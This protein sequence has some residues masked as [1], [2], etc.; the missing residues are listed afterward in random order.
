[1]HESKAALRI[2][3][4][5]AEAPRKARAHPAIHKPPQPRH[6]AGLGH[7]IADDEMRAGLAQKFRNVAGC[8]L[9]IT[10]HQQGPLEAVFMCVSQAALHRRALA[11]VFRMLDNFRASSRCFLSRSIIRTIIDHDDTWQQWQYTPYHSADMCGFVQARN[12]RC[13]I[14]PPCLP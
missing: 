9:S 11:L 14:H 8:V 1:M 3:Q 7:A 6:L 13:A 10:I 2:R 5:N 4:R 12:D